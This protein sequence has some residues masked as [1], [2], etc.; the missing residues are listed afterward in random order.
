MRISLKT[1]FFFSLI[2]PSLFVI[3]EESKT[4]G[5]PSLMLHKNKNGGDYD[6]FIDCGR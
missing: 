6:A 3:I 1:V 2:L 5:T 4:D